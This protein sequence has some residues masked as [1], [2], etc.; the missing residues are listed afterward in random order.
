V[1]LAPEVD[2]QTDA[3]DR[4]EAIMKRMIAEEAGGKLIIPHDCQMELYDRVAVKDNR[5][6]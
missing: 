1:Y 4:A 2:N 5:G 6:V 3:D